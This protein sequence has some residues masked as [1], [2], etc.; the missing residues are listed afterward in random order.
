MDFGGYDFR[1]FAEEKHFKDLYVAEEIGE[2]INDAVYARNKTVEERFN[3][4][5]KP[6]FYSSDWNR[7][8]DGEKSITAG[9]DD[10]DIMSLHG[11]VAYRYTENNLIADWFTS[12]PYVDF[13]APWWNQDIIKEC[14]MFDKLYFASGDI[15]YTGLG[16]AICLM[17]N[18]NLFQD[19]NIKYPYEEV[20]N[21]TWTLDK[22][23]SAVKSGAADLDGDGV[24]TPDKD[25]YG[26]DIASVWYYPTTV[27]Y[28]GGDRVVK[29]CEEESEPVLSLMNERTID[30]FDKFF[31]MLKN[32]AACISKEKYW[33]NY[34]GTE[35]FR[36]G[37]A[38]FIDGGM[39]SI[40]RYRDMEDEIGI[41]PVP[42][43]DEQTPKYFTI[44]EA[45]ARM[46]TVPVTQT[47]FDRTSII[48]E[49]LCVEGHKTIIPA[50]Y[51]KA[52]KTKYSYDKESA[53]MLDYIKDGRVFDFGYLNE[54]MVGNLA[55]V[56]AMLV[57]EQDA[58]FVSYYEKYEHNMKIDYEYA[59]EKF[60]GNTSCV[61][62]GN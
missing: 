17:F 16:S 50:Y 25:R 18:K 30:I 7:M 13:D 41:V 26:F 60:S 34:A 22:F 12:M 37:R 6:V 5:I 11:R 8:M 40:I 46:I 47:D 15:S 4:N 3:I 27:L 20:V 54:M 10:F 49:A 32:G 28:C 1:I 35:I 36:N 24:I 57:R 14:S 51:E 29:K 61:C 2:I 59:V 56:G 33:G 9:Y 19:L 45:Y 55:S 48:V 21:G 44:V 31:D 62:H 23:I 58:N 53:E 38:L 52:L 39:E 43:Y 42:K